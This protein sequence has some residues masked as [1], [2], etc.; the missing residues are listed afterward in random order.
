MG[1]FLYCY[2]GH[3]G[4]PNEQRPLLSGLVVRDLRSDILTP[5]TLSLSLSSRKFRL[6]LHPSQMSHRPSLSY[7]TPQIRQANAYD[8]V[9][10]T[11]RH[12][13]FLKFLVAENHAIIGFAEIFRT[14]LPS[15]LVFLNPGKMYVSSI[16]CH[17]QRHVGIRLGK[18]KGALSDVHLVA[19]MSSCYCFY[20]SVLCY[21]CGLHA[22]ET[23][24]EF[25]LVVLRVTERLHF[26]AAS[27]VCCS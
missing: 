23:A 2:S 3:R 6:S 18:L 25:Q 1:Q 10:L 7:C 17:H 20:W 21:N 9:T 16:P 15:H 11:R 8:T 27:A 12:K 13:V 22:C 5:V 19:D 4:L 26:Y 14:S 24:N